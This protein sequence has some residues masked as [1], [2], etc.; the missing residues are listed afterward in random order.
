M[1]SRIPRTLLLAMPALILLLAMPT[2]E[3][4]AQSKFKAWKG[5]EGR[6]VKTK[7]LAMPLTEEE[8]NSD[9]YTVQAWFDDG[10]RVWVS[11]L[12]NNFGPGTGKMTVKSRWYE[13]NGKEH[14]FK[15]KLKRGKYDTG[16]DPFYVEAAGHRISG[17][18]RRVKVKGKSKAF[19]YQLSFASG[20]RPYRPG[21][22]RTVFEMGDRETYFDTTMVQPK[23]KVTGWVSKGGT[24]KKLVGHG[25]VIHTHGNIAP[26]V[27][28]KRFV[29]LRSISGD[30]AVYIKQYKASSQLGNKPFGFIYIARG[31]KKILAKTRFRLKASKI[32]TDT[33]HRN[34]YKVPM[35]L[36]ATLKSKGTIIK[37]KVVASEIIGRE[38]ELASMSKFEAALV[39]QYAQPVSYTMKSKV[40]VSVQEGEG[41][42]VVS[43]EDA[44]Y[45]VSYL[46][47]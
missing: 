22:G 19:S 46:N 34:R 14:Y 38:D 24:K 23:A 44:A 13:A 5:G 12:V 11:M 20:L 7:H 2:L 33:K 9:R 26:Y 37:V 8:F 10:T 18:P 45:S 43:T 36:S 27:L 35:E 47:K 41:E 6:A 17:T 3:A 21:T 42:P 32:H 30:T 40:S 16:S 15:E 28:Y 1:S 29:E 31:G 25:Y 39:G 4:A